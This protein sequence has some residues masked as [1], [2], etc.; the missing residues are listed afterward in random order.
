M[1]FRRMF[2]DTLLRYVS[3][4]HKTAPV[5]RRERFHITKQ[6]RQ[7][8]T[9]SLRKLFP[10]LNALLLLVTCNRTELY[11]ESVQ[12][13]SAQIRDYIIRWKLGSVQKEDR[14]DFLLSERTE[15]TVEQLLKVSTGLESSVLGDAEIIHQ[16]KMAYYISLEQGLQGS[17][18]ERCMQS[19]FRC[20]KRVTNETDFRDGTTSTAY[21]A[22]KTIGH[23]Y[24]KKASSKKILIVGA[25]DIVRRIFKYNTKFGYRNIW[26]TNRTESKAKHLA[27]AHKMHTW[28]WARLVQNE[29]SEFDVIISAVSNSPSLIRGGIHATKNVLLLDLA[30]PANIAA[31]LRSKPNV[32]LKDMDSIEGQLQRNQEARNAAADDVSLLVQEEWNGYLQWYRMQPFRTLMAD[33]KAAVLKILAP[34]GKHEQTLY[35]QRELKDVSD[36]IMRRV[37]KRPEAFH[38]ADA[39]H[40]IVTEFLP[41]QMA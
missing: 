30:V 37:L 19:L 36:R 25:G 2:K 14:A 23:T 28:P 13:T 21:K 29:L 15:D 33:R 35:T 3:I 27:K 32:I 39:L 18:L 16:I 7:E 22:L 4:S 1:T 26:I 31:D 5:A 20:H 8:L 24:G 9:D 6:E 10:D 17:L 41:M 34:E 12:T 38:N 11:F 40:E